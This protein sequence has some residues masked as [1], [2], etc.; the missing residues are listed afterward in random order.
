MA[1]YGFDEI[2][3]GDIAQLSKTISKRD[4]E[5]FANITG[6]ENPVH[7][8]EEYS[9]NTPFKKPIVHGMLTSGLISTLLGN[10]LPGRGTIYVSQNLKFFLPVYLGDTVTA[11]VEVVKKIN[12]KKR[13][14]LKTS[15]YNQE[16]RV[17][18][19]GEAI[20]IPPRS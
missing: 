17:V 8:N 4:V 15:V 3:I 20:V 16:G 12:D 14:V 13:V 1:L 5:L 9:K 18:V 10:Y 7:L 19:G 2:S 6:D 11:T